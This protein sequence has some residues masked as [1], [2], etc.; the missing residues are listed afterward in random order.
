MGEFIMKKMN[1]EQISLQVGHLN[2]LSGKFI[3]V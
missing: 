3:I 2:F 1:K